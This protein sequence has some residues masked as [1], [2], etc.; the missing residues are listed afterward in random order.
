M[1]SRFIRRSVGQR[2]ALL[3]QEKMFDTISRAP[4]PKGKLIYRIKADRANAAV[5]QATAAIL[6]M[7]EN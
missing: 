6:A 4:R 3:W 2:R 5:V 7:W 1:P